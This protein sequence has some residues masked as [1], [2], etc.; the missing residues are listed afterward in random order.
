MRKWIVAVTFAAV[1]FVPSAVLSQAGTGSTG[2]TPGAPQAAPGAAQPAEPAVVTVPVLEDVLSSSD[3]RL[4]AGYASIESYDE[5][6]NPENDKTLAPYLFVAGGDPATERLPLKATTAEVRIVGVIAQV[7]IRQTFA[8]TGNKPIEAVYVFPASTRAAV[9]AMRMKIGERT[10]EAKIEKKETAKA[11]YEEAK[12]EGKR[13][14]LLEEQRPN[15]FTMSVA[16]IMPGDVIDVE[17]D[18]SELLVPEDARYEF[19]FPTVVGPRY[20]GGADAKK[21]GWIES[22][23]TPEGQKETYVFGISATIDS[24]IPIKEV[25]SPSHKIKVERP[26]PERAAVTL[27]QEGGGN[28]D[29]VLRFRLSGDKIES[30]VLLYEG[31]QEK[32]FVLMME[33]PRK[34]APS[35]IPPRE[36]IFLI[37]VSGSMEGFPL[38]TAKAVMKPLLSS[39]RDGDYFNVVFFAGG[40]YRLSKKSVPATWWNT[41]KAMKA[42]SKQHGGGGTEL[43]GG[44]EAAYGV[45]RVAEKGV[46]RTVVVVTDG[47][48]GVEAQA[49]KFIR[50]NLGETNLFAFGIGSSVNRALIEGMSRAGMG[51]PFIVLNEKQAE[52]EAARFRQYIESPVLTDI[53]VEFKDFKVFDVAPEKVPDLMARRPI[54]LQGKYEGRAQGT[55]R[56]SGISGDG[57]YTRTMDIGKLASGESHRPIRVLWARTW[58]GILEDQLAMLPGDAELEGAITGLGLTYSILTPFTSFVAIDSEVVNKGGPL[59][60]VEQPLPMPEGVS[61]YALAPEPGPSEISKYSMAMPKAPHKAAGCASCS[62]SGREADKGLPLLFLLA[63]LGAWLLLCLRRTDR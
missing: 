63:F 20:G 5:S 16:N 40:S 11:M 3:G 39:L 45:P 6:Y 17:L 18:Y 29:F 44:L 37:D 7:R 38:D 60:N 55:V 31:G 30:G 1:A 42:V 46:S 13:A 59:E 22:P 32:F 41:K 57:E 53:A 28:K 49:F 25:V 43:M 10:V 26:T 12:E 52:E 50:E 48:V 15:V 33:P 21:D 9:H 56:V 24:A 23:T 4:P 61:N 47:Y 2:E 54:V 19:V 62:V 27:D 36:Y 51:E 8:N 58:V 34:P 14:S 35:Q